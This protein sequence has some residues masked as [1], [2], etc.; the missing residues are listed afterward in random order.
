MLRA[1]TE[2]E[3]R[4]RASAML[5]L[6]KL[7]IVGGRRAWLGMAAP[8]CAV[9]RLLQARA[10]GPPP[11]GAGACADHPTRVPHSPSTAQVDSS[12]CELNPCGRGTNLQLLFT[13]LNPKK[14]AAP[15]PVPAEEEEG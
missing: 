6:T 10:V 4:L 9:L 7:M 2:A 15:R 11:A 14:A 8:G 3:K 13:L 5:A 1:G 12:F